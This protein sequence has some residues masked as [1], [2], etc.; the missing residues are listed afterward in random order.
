MKRWIEDGRL[1]EV[2]LAEANFSNERGLELTPQTWRWYADKSPGG[3]FI[4]LGVHHADTL[5]FLLGPVKS[6]SAHARKLYTKSEVPDA[7][8]A[9]PRVRERRAR[10]HR[11]RLGLP[12][13]LLDEPAR[14]QGQP[15]VRP[16]LHAL[17]RVPS[18]RRLV[19]AAARSSTA[20]PSA[21]S[22]S[23]RAPTCSASSSRSSAWPRAAEATVEVGATEAVRALAVVRAVIESSARD[24]E[25]VHARRGHRGRPGG[26]HRLRD[27]I[28]PV[29]T[30]HRPR[31]RPAA[32]AAL[33]RP[34]ARRAGRGL[35]GPGG[36]RAARLPHATPPPAQ[37][38]GHL[39]RL[40][41]SATPG[42]ATPVR[43]SGPGD[44]CSC[45]RAR[46]TPPSRRRRG[47]R[48]ALLLPARRPRGNLVE[49]D[50]PLAQLGRPSG[51]PG[52]RH[53]GGQRAEPLDLDLEHVAARGGTA[54]ASSPCPRPA[55]YR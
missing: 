30:Q 2:S 26:A 19:D 14:H 18:R 8:M 50:G 17:G 31:L 22:S 39:R 51:E 37:R 3:A 43:R 16:R 9:V 10:L 6:V 46:R 54:A 41:Q 33:G 23:S 53:R 36:P 7:I 32:R 25:A 55:A 21:R 20:S 15:D 5:Q 42:R 28:V 29:V 12:G 34:R 27:S 49:L 4:Q 1:G 45:P 11:H 47:A 13:R 38:R 40:G 24:G 44:V 52:R 48:A 35:R